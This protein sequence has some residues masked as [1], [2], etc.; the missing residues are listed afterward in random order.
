MTANSKDEK[1]A[2]RFYEE[3]GT[4]Y[5]AREGRRSLARLSKDDGER[6]KA[7]ILALEVKKKVIGSSLAPEV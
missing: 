6:L 5:A 7:S 3:S 4:I 1:S 2:V